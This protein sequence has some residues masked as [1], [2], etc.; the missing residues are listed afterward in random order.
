M[1][2]R[3]LLR[4]ATFSALFWPYTVAMVLLG[5]PLLPA[6]RGWLRVHVRAWARGVLWLL[7]VAAGIRLRVTGAEHL[8]EGAAILAAK[9]QSSFDTIVWLALLPRPAY[10]MKVELLRIPLWGWLAQRSGQIAV[11]RGAGAAAL[12]GMLREGTAA[13]AEG[14]QVVI[15]PEGT[16]TAAGERTPYQP[17]VAALAMAAGPGVPVVPVATDSGCFWGRHTFRKRPGTLT[18][19]VLPPLP[20]GLPRAVLMARLAEAIETESDRLLAE[21]SWSGKPV[22]KFVD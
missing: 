16:R 14:R 10:V 20:P 19:A 18:V 22:D 9:H 3:R 5:V 13:L 8:P 11:D 21:V 15:F 7:R 2:L 4:S 12:R 6:P 1:S 17:G